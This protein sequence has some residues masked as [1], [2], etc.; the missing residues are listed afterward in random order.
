MKY[1]RTASSSWLSARRES[2]PL[3]NLTTGGDSHA[4][5]ASIGVWYRSSG[6]KFAE[7]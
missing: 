4:D 3:I 7:K 5:D 2:V 6:L 1:A